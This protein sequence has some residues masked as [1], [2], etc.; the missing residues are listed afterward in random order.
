MKGRFWLLA[1]A[2]AGVV[3]ALTRVPYL[4][5]AARS[6]ADTLVRLVASG[7]HKLVTEAAA[8]GASARVVLGLAGLVAA[9][10]PGVT[11]FLL[12][13]AA[14]GTLRLRAVIALLIAAAGAAAFAY[15]PHGQALGVLVLVLAVGALAVVVTGPV[16]AAPLCALAGLI[17][18]Q[19]LPRLL[20]GHVPYGPVQ[21]LHLALYDVP[22]A[23][24]AL[25]LGVLIVACVPFA[26][27]LRSILTS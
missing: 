9:L 14:K 12:V 4:A 2:A 22:G 17:A 11:A 21:Q 24:L 26:L 7:G 19:Y 1:G 6:L 10:L 23:P 18:G 27:A 20:A 25:R 15:R 16:V 8:H 3:L 13:L 5:G